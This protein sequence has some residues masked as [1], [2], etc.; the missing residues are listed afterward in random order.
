MRTS[1]PTPTQSA[2][3]RADVTPAAPLALCTDECTLVARVREGDT[4]AFDE[5]FRSYYRGIRMFIESYV[6]S[7]GAAEECAQ[8]V[9]M[10]I[11]TRRQDW[12]VSLSIRSYLYAA[13]R[14]RAIQFL[15]HERVVRQWSGRAGRG[16]LPTGMSQGVTGADA[17]LLRADLAAAVDRVLSRL[18][19]RTR[20]AWHLR[21]D[22]ALTYAE[23]AAVMGISV[24]G[25]EFQMARAFRALREQLTDFR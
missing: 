2:P 19:E 6:A 25:V 8:D 9:F 7:A 10:K 18:P 22:H 16:E 13:A 12:Q 4:R 17:A 23:V 21:I 24:K 14:N 20:V 3:D 15:K 5:I 1:K 11:W